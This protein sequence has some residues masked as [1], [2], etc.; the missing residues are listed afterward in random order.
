VQ[1]VLKEAQQALQQHQRAAAMVT[2]GKGEVWTRGGLRGDQAAWLSLA[3]LRE[4]RQH[5][6]AV[7]VRRLLAL[8]PWLQQQGF[9]VSGRPSCQLAS[10]PGGGARFVRHRDA[11]ASVPYR[12]VTVLLY[13]N[14]GAPQQGAAILL[15]WPLVLYGHH[16][17]Q[18]M[19]SR[20]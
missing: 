18:L 3:A 8:Q 9:D 19:A 5:H 17:S 12:T 14:P 11:S 7:V 1:A 20:S 2:A 6:L 16:N 4:A 13:L 10:F 15:H